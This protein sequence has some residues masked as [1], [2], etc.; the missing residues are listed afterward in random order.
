MKLISKTL[1][2][3]LCISVFATSCKRE[4]LTTVNDEVSPA[5]LQQIAAQ[6]FSAEGVRKVD[7]GYLVE[8]DIV[9][10]NENLS[11]TSTSPSLVIANVE[12]YRTGPPKN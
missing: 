7:N 10:T 6:G 2:A 12:Q 8:G 4:N 5:V 9:L 11:R 1:M 3:I